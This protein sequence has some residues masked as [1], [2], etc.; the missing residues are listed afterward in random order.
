MGVVAITGLSVDE[1]GN[2][3]A[4]TRL[5]IADWNVEWKFW[6]FWQAKRGTEGQGLH[7]PWAFEVVIKG[8]LAPSLAVI[9][10]TTSVP[11]VGLQ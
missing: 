8:C 11:G 4:V 3:D 2:C 7:G 6:T 1:A 10:Y 5:A 9:T